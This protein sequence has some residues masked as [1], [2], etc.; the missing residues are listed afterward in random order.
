MRWLG[1]IGEGAAIAGFFTTN[2][3][4]GAAVGPSND[5]ETADIKIYSGSSATQRTS[6]AGYTIVTNFDGITGLHLV[7]I[8]TNDDTD[9]GFYTAGKSYVVV[10][11]ADTETVD[12]KTVV[13]VLFQFGIEDRYF[14]STES[15]NDI[16][17]AVWD[18]AVAGHVAAG[19]FGKTDADIL[20]DTADMQPKLGAPAADVSADIAAVKVDSAAILVDT[21]EIGVAGISLTAL[22][23]MSAAMKLQVNAEVDGALNTTIPGSPVADSVNE[24]VKAI[25]DKL[26]TGNLVDSNDILTTALTEAYAADGSPAT[27]AQLLYM[28]WSSLSEFG[29]SGTT[30]TAKKLDGSTTSM[31]FTL[32]DDA[33]P[34]SRTRAT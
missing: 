26:P 20:I 31:T 28:L 32:D 24:R 29:I 25:D 4:T 11:D 27:L 8:D 1:N 5:W 17:D 23:G 22:G 6:E 14:G 7:T 30:I 10:L 12:G 9:V 18:E 34:T 2:D 13:A 21:V 19:T 3:S 15:K 33:S 16:A